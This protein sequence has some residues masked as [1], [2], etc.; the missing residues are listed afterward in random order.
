MGY[1]WMIM[2]LISNSSLVKKFR[3]NNNQKNNKI[4]NI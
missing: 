1:G 2:G 3:D 4:N